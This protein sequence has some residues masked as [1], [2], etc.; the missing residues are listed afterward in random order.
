M[1]TNIMTTPPIRLDISAQNNSN[2][3]VQ[4]SRAPSI[5]IN[6]SNNQSSI[7]TSAGG[8]NNYNSLTHKPSINGV[9]LEGNLSEE[10]L[11]ISSDKNFLYVQNEASAEWSIT[12]NLNK[13]PSV[14]VIDSAGNEVFGEVSYDN[15]NSVT[16]RFQG[17]FKG[18][19]TLN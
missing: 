17:S 12:H 6:T 8:S 4:T 1:V 9:T 3:L 14:T 2:I 5:N 10:D 16:I 15:I 7:N 11:H 19:A 13:Y 18:T